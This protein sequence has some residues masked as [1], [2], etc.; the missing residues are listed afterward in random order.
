MIPFTLSR[1]FFSRYMKTVFW[2]FL[3]VASIIFLIDFSENSARL[4]SSEHVSTANVFWLTAIRLP[5]VLQQTVPFV[6][7]FSGITALISLNKKYVNGIC[8]HGIGKQKNIKMNCLITL[9][10]KIQ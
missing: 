1:Y 10:E 6:I 5:L 3:G 8:K 2:F 4:S 7:L 9:K